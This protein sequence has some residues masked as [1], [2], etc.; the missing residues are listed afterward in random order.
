[1]KSPWGPDRELTLDLSAY[2]MQ[3]HDL[4]VVVPGQQGAAAPGSAIGNHGK[5]GSELVVA[6][7]PPGN[8]VDNLSGDAG[9][10]QCKVNEIF[11]DGLFY[12]GPFNCRPLKSNFLSACQ[13]ISILDTAVACHPGPPK[14]I[15]LQSDEI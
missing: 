8:V 12:I 13:P 2:L 14:Y 10:F 5:R 15:I 4:L 3:R 1:M 6:Q 11:K 7:G 9:R